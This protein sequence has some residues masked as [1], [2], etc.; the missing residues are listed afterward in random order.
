[1]AKLS[2]PRKGWPRRLLARLRKRLPLRVPV[3]LVWRKD[4]RCAGEIVLGYAAYRYAW[5]RGKR[6]RLQRCWIVLDPRLSAGQAWDALIHEYAH[7]LDRQ[8]RKTPK[9]CHDTRWGQCYSRVFRASFA[10]G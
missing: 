9:D 6:G 2:T 4:P 3:R 1:M 8:S 5:S 10:D 7:C